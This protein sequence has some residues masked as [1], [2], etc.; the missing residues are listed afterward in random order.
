MHWGATAKL[1]VDIYKNEQKP[2]EEHTTLHRVIVPRLNLREATPFVKSLVSFSR[3]YKVGVGEDR[4]AALGEKYHSYH[5]LMNTTAKEIT[6]I[7]GIG[8]R[9]AERLLTALGGQVIE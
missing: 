5:E 2:P 3:A 9:T 4:A 7:P 6:T 8:K 1:L